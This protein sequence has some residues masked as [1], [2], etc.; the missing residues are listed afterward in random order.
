MALYHSPSIVT[1]GLML[2][3]DAANIKSYPGTGT[4]WTDLSGNNKNGTL[5]NSPT[6]SNNVFTFNGSTQY[7]STTLTYANNSAYTMGCWIKTSTSQL[8][9]LI[10]FR[11]AFSSTSWQTQFYIAGNADAN[12]S[13]NYLKFDEWNLTSGSFTA[14]RSIFV[15]TNS[16]VTGN[17]VNITATSDSTGARI[18]INGSLVAQDSSTPQ[19]TRLDPATFT[20]AAAGDYPNSPLS[21]YYFNGSMNGVCFYNRALSNE[22]VKRNFNALRGRYGI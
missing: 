12:I 11:K 3:L 22:E 10:G 5:V 9:G 13:G 6:Y 18:Y 1:D 15:N 20:I 8:S 19:A 14:R 4:T 16:V 17:W 21:G 7:T 2:C